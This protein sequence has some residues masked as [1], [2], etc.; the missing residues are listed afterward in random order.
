MD[1][2]FVPMTREYAQA[3]VEGWKYGGEYSI[4]DY[5][6][7]ADH[8]LDP[9]A[10]EAGI[11]AVL[12]EAGELVGE[13]SIEFLDKSDQ[14]TEYGEFGDSALI[15][16]REMWIGFGMRPELVGR[17]LGP[18]F[19]R[20]CVSHVVRYYGYRGEYVRLGVAAFNRRAIKAY[21]RAGFEVYDQA[22]GNI[23]GREYD[24]VYMRRCLQAE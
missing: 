2:K 15:N 7:E 10:W 1:Y 17:K 13:V 24:S 16:S 22:R 4:Y 12:D 14:Y 23:A 3:I 5:S 21:E 18:G 19:V 8:M 6:N 9:S 11:F 20:A